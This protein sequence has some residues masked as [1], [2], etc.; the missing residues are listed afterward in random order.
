LVLVG[1]GSKY[2]TKKINGISHF[3]EHM[4]FK[5]TADRPSPGQVNRELDS[6]GAQHNAFTS[7]EVTGYWV[8]AAKE[9]FDL[10]LDIV[11]DILTKPLLSEDE[12]EKEKGVVIQEIRMR[13]DDP[14]SRAGY[15]FEK[16]LWGDQPAG[17]EIAGDEA[18]VMSLKREDFLDYFSSQYTAK[19]SIVVIAGN[20]PKDAAKKIGRAFL[21]LK[22]GNPAKMSL[23]R[24]SGGFGRLIM[25]KKENEA[26]NFILGFKGF[27]MYS[28]KRYALEML[29]VILGG[30]SSSRLFFEV[31]EKL[32]LAY[33]IG[34]GATLYADS[35]YFEISA[36]VPHDKVEKVL[37]V[38]LDEI[39][40]IKNGGVTKEELKKAMDFIRGTSKIS[41]ENSSTLASFFAE[42]VIFKKPMQTPE[43]N[44][45]MLEK[46]TEDDIK[47]IANEIFIGES[48]NL[49]LVG[50]DQNK[51][52]L[53][54]L[55]NKV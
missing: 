42:Q 30:N 6:I 16:L 51:D 54:K 14:M 20:Y 5:G 4:F 39:K 17:W 25:E 32:G 37:E 35:G 47:K 29:G 52:R 2:E 12:I 22:K 7:K 50:V 28:P 33:Y 55:L 18:T 36:G 23:I 8:K 1:T 27:N 34:A 24:E 38:V 13:N 40:K 19:N 44:L 11:S 43:E 48:A 9:N 21:L 26:S 53:T 31:R 3:L 46:V 45:K 15:I 10:S 41:L 49:A